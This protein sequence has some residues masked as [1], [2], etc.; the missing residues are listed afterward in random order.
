MLNDDLTVFDIKYNEGMERLNNLLSSE[1]TTSSIK[2][3]VERY[4]LDKSRENRISQKNNNTSNNRNILKE[5]KRKQIVDLYE[6]RDHDKKVQHYMNKNYLKNEI[7]WF[8][9]K[10]REDE[11]KNK[12]SYNRSKLLIILN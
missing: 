7:E 4:R 9:I 10:K 8:K 12:Y 6:I 5:D 11:H 3:Y 2:N 1:N